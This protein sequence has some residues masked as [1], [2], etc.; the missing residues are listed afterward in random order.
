MNTTTWRPFYEPAQ[1]KNTNSFFIKILLSVLLSSSFLIPHLI[2]VEKQFFNDWS[3]LLA[4]IIAVA[5]LCVYYAT[6]TLRGLLPEI[7]ARLSREAK[8]EFNNLLRDRLSNYRLVRTGIMFGVI[9]CGFAFVFGYP[10]GDQTAA[11]ISINYGYFIA[12]FVCGMAVQGIF[13]IT[14]LM[15]KH[16]EAGRESYDFTA[17]DNCGGTSYLGAAIYIFS[18]VCLIVSVLISI[19]IVN[20]DWKNNDTAYFKLML[21]LWIIFPYTVSL[22]ALIAPAIPINLQLQHY[23]REQDVKIQE[24]IAGIRSKLQGDNHPIADIKSLREEYDYQL[25]IRDRL[26]KMRTWPFSTHTNLEYLIA[27]T[28]GLGASISSCYDWIT[29]AM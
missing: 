5:M 7:E 23:K 12:G 2:I 14:L 10:Y 13:G 9:N 8:S 18:L 29:N 25:S 6:H 1:W 20:T 16:A 27:V 17:A 26:H 21:W 3:W 15:Q 11:N 28:G 24:K 19:Y 22:C 4:T